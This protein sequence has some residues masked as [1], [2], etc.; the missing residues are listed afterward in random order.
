[1][2]DNLP[3]PS[4]VLTTPAAGWFKTPAALGTDPV[5]L[6]TPDEL[7]IACIGL[8][9]SSIGW[10]LNHN[11]K[12]GWIPEPAISFGQVIAAP[13]NQLQEVAA[14]LVHAGLWLPLELDGIRGF[15]V[16][17]AATAVQ[18]RFARQASASNAGRTSQ[19]SQNAKSA[20]NGKKKI[21]AND[22]TDW[23]KVS[24]LL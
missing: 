10:A 22:P 11:A 14:A 21:D 15:V 18:E 3:Q 19:M 4:Y 1:M 5:F 7:R 17:G 16:A 20:P 8:F 12:N 2:D 6:R 24:E 13:S 23:S 9:C